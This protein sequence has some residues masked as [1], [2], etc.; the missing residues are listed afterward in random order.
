MQS[1]TPT[2]D[3]VPGTSQLRLGTVTIPFATAFFWTLRIAVAAEYIGHGAFGILRKQGWIPYFGV[4]SIGSESALQLMPWVGT[5]DIVMGIIALISPRRIV[6]L[7]MA[8]W[9]L[10]TALLRPLSGEPFWE[11]IERSYN[12]GVPFVFLWWVGF[13]RTLR[14]WFEPIRIP[15][16]D[17]TWE[18][19][20]ILFLRGIAAWMLIGHGLLGALSHKSLL[21][22]H[23]GAAGLQALGMPLPQLAAFIGWFEV[24]LGILV[25]IRPWRP[26]LVFILV[27]KVV[28]ELLHSVN[29]QPIWEFVERGGAY[30]TPIL[31]LL[32]FAVCGMQATRRRDIST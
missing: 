25:F 4:A 12:Y 13:G 21:A 23:Y 24:A 14:A 3:S 8:I 10:W 19:R 32:L 16:P 11:F 2:T 22:Q 18:A 28:T 29:H 31:M 9:G 15:T 1:A 27:W 26:L 7:H 17:S 6:L 20:A 30:A 5:F